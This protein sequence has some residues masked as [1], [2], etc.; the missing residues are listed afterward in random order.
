MELRSYEVKEL[1]QMLC[2]RV[3]NNLVNTSNYRK[4]TKFGSQ[5]KCLVAEWK[6]SLTTR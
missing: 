2:C 3:E 6:T 4:S 5:A 1:S